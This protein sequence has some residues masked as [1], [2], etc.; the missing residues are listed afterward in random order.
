MSGC[1]VTRSRF[2]RLEGLAALG[3]LF[4]TFRRTKDALR[5]TRVPHKVRPRDHFSPPVS[6]LQVFLSIQRNDSSHIQRPTL[7]NQHGDINHN[8]SPTRSHI[9]QHLTAHHSMGMGHMHS[10]STALWQISLLQG[11]ESRHGCCLSSS[12]CEIGSRRQGYRRKD[13]RPNSTL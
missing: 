6:I 8:S 12:L 13:P 5:N 4:E 11:D 10:W 3:T 1:G 2:R 9:R 7:Y